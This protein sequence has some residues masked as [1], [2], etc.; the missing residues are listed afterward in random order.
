MKIVF[1]GTP[2]FAARQLEFI[3]A[4]GI[5]VCAVVTAPDKPAG[6]G[7][8]LAA[9]EV[10]QAAIR[11]GLPVLQ[12]VLL[13]EPS[14]LE[15]LQSFN[16]DLFVVIAFRMLPDLV[17]KIPPA[18]TFNLHASKLPDYRGAAPINRAIMNGETT[19]GLTTFFINANIDTGHIIRQTDLKI[20]DN[21]TA[22]ELH[23]RMI[24]IGQQLVLDTIRDI[25]LG[26][27]TTTPQ[28]DVTNKP[29]KTAPKLHK[30]DGKIDWT[31]TLQSVHNHIRG[32]SPHPGAYC[33]LIN[34]KNETLE[35][36]ILRSTIETCVHN[37]TVFALLTDNRSQ[38]KVALKEGFL[39]LTQ[40][41]QAGKKSLSTREFLNGFKFSGN[42]FA[43]AAF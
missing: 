28:I 34:E 15:T 6:R 25:A 35:L 43:D 29:L 33:R 11:L 13:R 38:L 18:G 20:D 24:E 10:K 21:E 12:P 16:A 4:H 5:D 36:K 32:L 2:A 1:F 31:K 3:A 39:H 37:E 30:E 22:G 19:T 42:W 41:Q 9:S 40:I 26:K 7:K 8:K 17:W 27:A 23:D 14:F